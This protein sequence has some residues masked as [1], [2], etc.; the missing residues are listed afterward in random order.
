MSDGPK[1]DVTADR[2]AAALRCYGS[3]GET[4]KKLVNDKEIPTDIGAAAL[5]HA[6]DIFAAC[7]V[8]KDELRQIV[9]AMIEARYPREVPTE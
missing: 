2:K 1:T 6:V 3:I 7:R 5:A 9:D 8:S 4:T